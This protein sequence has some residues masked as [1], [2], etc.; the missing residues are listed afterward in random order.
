MTKD[1]N[2]PYGEITV[3]SCEVCK[4]KYSLQEAKERNMTC[5]GQPLKQVAKNV[6]VPLGP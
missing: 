6:S 5:C 1:P 3:N 4:T 2:R